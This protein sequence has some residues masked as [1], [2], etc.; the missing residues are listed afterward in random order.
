MSSSFGGSP[1]P[2][3]KKSN[4]NPDIA[5]VPVDAVYGAVERNG[6]VDREKVCAL[7]GLVLALKQLGLLVLKVQVVNY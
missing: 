6:S 1:P 3:K 4:N 5:Y 2:P 7:L